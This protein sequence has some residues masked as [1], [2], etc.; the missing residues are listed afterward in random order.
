VRD[1]DE[2]A[3]AL[4]AAAASDAVSLVDVVTDPDVISP[5]ARLSELTAET[6]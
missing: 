3:P 5:T 1:P 4:Q 2:L 6:T